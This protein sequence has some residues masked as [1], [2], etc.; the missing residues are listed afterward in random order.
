M[1]GVY[2]VSVNQCQAVPD[3]LGGLSPHKY[4]T[5]LINYMIITVINK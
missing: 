2:N 4:R 5:H 3:T 1:S